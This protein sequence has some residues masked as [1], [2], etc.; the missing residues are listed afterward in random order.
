MGAGHKSDGVPPLWT[1]SVGVIT[2]LHGDM[3]VLP[4]I[5]TVTQAPDWQAFADS[6]HDLPADDHMGDGGAY[7]QRRYAAFR[8]GMSGYQR[9][10]HRS[11]YQERAHNCLNGGIQRWFAP[12]QPATVSSDAF[13]Q[14]M[15]CMADAVCER[16]GNPSSEWFVEVHQFRIMAQNGLP[17]LPTPEGLHH[18]GRD[19]VMILYVGGENFAGG[20]TSVVGARE[21][22]LRHRLGQPGEALFLDDRRLRHATSAIVPVRPG[23]PAWRDTLVITY[24]V[25][26]DRVL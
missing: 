6:W 23:L 17:G 2:Q 16:E 15:H 3:L 20:E 10:R 9:L 18:D 22:V 21:T 19:W 26:P 7:R 1:A 25:M 13:A 11:H 14:A 5:S 8:A 12:M 4:A 24:T